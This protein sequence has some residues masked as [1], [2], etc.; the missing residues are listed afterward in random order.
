MIK[1]AS[2][3]ILLEAVDIVIFANKS[4]AHTYVVIR[5]VFRGSSRVLSSLLSLA[6]RLNVL[7][8]IYVGFGRDLEKQRQG[9]NAKLMYIPLLTVVFL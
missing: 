4:R 1:F 2:A 9:R 7:A 8:A 6:I 5:R 3:R